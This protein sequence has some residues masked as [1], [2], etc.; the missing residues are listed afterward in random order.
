MKTSVLRPTYAEYMP[1]DLDPGILYI[2]LQ[3]ATA[4]HLCACGCGSKVVTPLAPSGWTM[5]FDGTVTLRPSIGNGQ[6]PCRSHYLITHDAIS[7]LRPIGASAT[8]AAVASDRRVL[9]EVHLERPSI[10][11]RILRRVL[12]AVTSP[13]G[14]N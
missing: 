9:A 4:V 12:G 13:T 8:E 2:S 14:K 5:T 11:R 10:W 3:Y 1:A 6:F 7:W